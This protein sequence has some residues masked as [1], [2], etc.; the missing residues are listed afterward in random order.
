M[1]TV[2]AFA[3]G[4]GGSL[5]FGITD[6]YE[7]TG[8]Q[9]AAVAGIQDRISDLIDRWVSPRPTWSF[10]IYPIDKVPGSVV[11]ALPCVARS[12]A[13]VRRRLWQHDHSVLRSP[14]WTFRTGA[15]QTSS[16]SSHAQDLQ[17]NPQV[18]GSF[19]PAPRRR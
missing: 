11:L 12:G 8:I 14:R 17:A 6:E 15:I 16:A 19:A 9:E 7:T 13:A 3:N 4:D 18:D 2:A 1:K 5:L 10:E